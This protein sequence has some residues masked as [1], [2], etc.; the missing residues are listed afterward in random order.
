[1]N[2]LTEITLEEK[3][4]FH[5]GKADG[6]AGTKDE[7]IY[8]NVENG[9]PY[10]NGYR[11]GRMQRDQEGDTTDHSPAGAGPQAVAPLPK[12]PTKDP[13]PQVEEKKP[14]GTESTAEPQLELF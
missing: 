1:M 14:T 11:A 9:L 12:T 4:L 13:E 10:R 7:A 2:S 5:K 8:S 6:L 3:A